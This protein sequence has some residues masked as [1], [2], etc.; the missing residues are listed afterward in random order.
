MLELLWETR[1]LRAT[2]SR[3][4]QI[5]HMIGKRGEAMVFDSVWSCFEH[6][7]DAEPCLTDTPTPRQQ[8]VI[9]GMVP[10]TAV[11]W[12]FPLNERHFA[13]PYR[14][15]SPPRG[16]RLLSPLEQPA[17][18]RK[19]LA[20]LEIDRI[21]NHLTMSNKIPKYCLHRKE[22]FL[23]QLGAQTRSPVSP[24]LVFLG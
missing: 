12:G 21:V 24:E 23:A 4:N 3:A 19:A 15:L 13:D 9:D 20:T 17:G 8:A 5:R 14:P 1:R 18:T 10:D 7:L 11:F 22:Q 16:Q 6:E 2:I